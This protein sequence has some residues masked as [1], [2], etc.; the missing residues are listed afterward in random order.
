ML[1][2]ECP[3]GNDMVNF[4]NPRVIQEL[5]K[6]ESKGNGYRLQGIK[7]CDDSMIFEQWVFIKSVK[8]RNPG[9]HIYIFKEDN[10]LRAV[11]WV[12]KNGTPIKVPPCQDG[13]CKNVTEP[14]LSIGEDVY[15]WAK[16][17][18]DHGVVILLYPTTEW[19]N[20]LTT[21][22]SGAKTAR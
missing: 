2:A 22:S 14:A 17:Q 7:L 3:S 15:T 21:V 20:D 4:E 16:V 8:S 1:Y 5:K 6:I 13:D 18:P 12:D 9:Q 10:I 11:V 19:I